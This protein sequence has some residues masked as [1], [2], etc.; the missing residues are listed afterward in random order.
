M[1]A[2]FN[3]SRVERLGSLFRLLMLTALFSVAGI[4]SI[5]A[6][7]SY[8][9]AARL[10]IASR[11]PRLAATISPRSELTV[12]RSIQAATSAERMD[13]AS[14]EAALSADSAQLLQSLQ[15]DVAAM[16]RDMAE[17]KERLGRLAAG[18]DQMTRDLA[19]ARQPAQRP[20]VR[21]AMAA[22]PTQNSP[23]A[24]DARRPLVV[25]PTVSSPTVLTPRPR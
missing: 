2:I 24:P 3:L 1:H 22:A 11:V 10:A 14:P 25:S 19:K 9:E 13:G 18:Q 6:W 23:A 17:L 4:V 5:S 16:G 20:D 8:G 12:G 15:R 7:Q 21:S